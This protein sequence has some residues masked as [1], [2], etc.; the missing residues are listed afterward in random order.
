MGNLAIGV[1]EWGDHEIDCHETTLA[2]ADEH[3]VAHLF[4]LCCALNG[5]AK[6]GLNFRR[7]GPPVRFLEWFSQ[8]IFRLERREPERGPVRLDEDALWRHYSHEGDEAVHD[9][10]Q[11]FFTQA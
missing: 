11:V 9:G 5:A 3:V 4:P 2:D 6:C 1:C 8:Y 10:S 7:V